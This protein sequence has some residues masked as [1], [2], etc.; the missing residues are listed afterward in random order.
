MDQSSATVVSNQ[1]EALC[2]KEEV[3]REEGVCAG[4]GSGMEIK[5]TL[6]FVSGAMTPLSRESSS[7]HGCS[8]G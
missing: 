8:Q 2:L 6:L 4:A 5:N 7:L 3:G 1:G